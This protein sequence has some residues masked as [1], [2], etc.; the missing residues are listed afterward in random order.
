V[1]KQQPTKAHTAYF[2]V[3]DEVLFGKYKNKRGKVVGWGEDKWGNPT[4]EI[5]P[6]P[7]GRKKNQTI[8]LYRIWRADVKEKGKTTVDEGTVRVDDA[9]FAQDDE[10]GSL[11]FVGPEHAGKVYQSKTT[12]SEPLSSGSPDAQFYSTLNV[13]L[14][15]SPGNKVLQSVAGKIRSGE[16]L[17]PD[18]RMSA[19]RVFR[20]LNLEHYR[21][22][23]PT[24]KETYLREEDELPGGLADK[25]TPSDF[26]PKALAK[27]T[28]VE[29]EHTSDPKL[30]REIAMDHLTED[31]MYYEKLETI[32]E[33]F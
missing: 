16:K 23:Y 26:D 18:Q 5:E 28:K 19:S 4:I 12:P 8:G 33:R 27:G 20:G 31:P 15:R 6:V 24:L 25:K 11:W 22:K 14:A 17:T 9:G 7:K 21:R 32:E 1:A 13:A 10:E 30:A 3:G 29:L 2:N